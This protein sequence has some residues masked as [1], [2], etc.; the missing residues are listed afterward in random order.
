[1]TGL[2]LLAAAFIGTILADSIQL[3]FCK[4]CKCHFVNNSAQADVTCTTNI[5]YNIFNDYFWKNNATNESYAYASI[6][7]QN[8]QFI[9]LSYTFPPSELTYLNLANNAIYG[10]ADSVFQNLQ[11]METLILSYND[12]EILHPDALKGQYLELRYLPLRS[13]KELRLDHNKLHTLNQDLFMH[14]TDLEILDLSFNPI[15]TI[16]HHTLAAIDS[17]AVLK[18]LYLQ[19][20]KISTL[21]DNM[22]HTPKYLEILDL[23]GNPIKEIPATLKQAHSLKSLYLNN[24]DFVNLTAENGL[25]NL[26][27]LYM[28]DNIDLVNIDP[29]AL[30]SV[31]NNSG[32]AV[33]PPIKKLHIG[34][35]KLA[36]LDSDIIARWDA[37]SELDIRPIHGLANVKKSMDDRGFNAYASKDQRRDG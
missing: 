24:T 11:N 5:Q 28:C 35:N 19:Y 14:T 29:M 34:N 12:L 10:I 4:I 27:E 1:M 13:L 16:D 7:F 3:P 2:Y 18:E 15:I 6:N 32:G 9:N 36:Y 26:E 22:L 33:W 25:K 23:S 8:N 37:L 31:S 20:T 30:A 17:L 21:P